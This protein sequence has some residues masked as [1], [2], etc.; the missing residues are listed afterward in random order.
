MPTIAARLDVLYEVNRRLSTFTDLADLVRYATRRAREVFEAEGCAL[1]I[2]DRER[3]EFYFPVSSQSESRRESEARL[4]EIRF[5]ADRG[6]AGWVLAHGESAL[7]NDVANDPRFYEDVDRKTAITTHA[8]LCA[9]L[10]TEWGN[11][12]VIEVVNPRAALTQ[13]DLEFLEALA[14]DIAIAH[15]KVALHEQLEG[16]VIGLRQVCAA[17]G[18]TLAAVGAFSCLAAAFVHLAWALPVRELPTRPGVWLGAIS[19]TVGFALF[20]VARG[21]LVRRTPAR[22]PT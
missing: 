21:W 5:P 18:A 13:E 6:I 17:A 8:V 20:A 19:L 16:E 11:I 9:P 12:G 22:V 2:L 10:R 3:N 15:E 4:A 7:V 14:G 1:L